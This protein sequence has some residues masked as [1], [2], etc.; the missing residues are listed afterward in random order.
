MSNSNAVVPISLKRFESLH[1]GRKAKTELTRNIT[2]YAPMRR[3][4]RVTNG[5]IEWRKYKVL[6][7]S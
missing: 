6:Q 1:T 4:P 7:F 2:Y 5:L 3:K